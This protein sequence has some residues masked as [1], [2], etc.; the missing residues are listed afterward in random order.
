MNVAS[1]DSKS[2]TEILRR[3]EI[4]RGA[5]YKMGKVF[6]TARVDLA[7]R[8]RLLKCYVWSILSYGAETWT[9]TSRL[10]EKNRGI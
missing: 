2:D 4:A 8:K 3:I 1:D 5:F 6:T 10:C 9:L 7:T